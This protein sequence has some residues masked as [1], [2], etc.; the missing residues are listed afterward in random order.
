MVVFVSFKREPPL[1]PPSYGVEKRRDHRNELVKKKLQENICAGLHWAI[2]F[3]THRNL[4]LINSF[5]M[6]DSNCNASMRDCS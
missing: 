5:S 2:I 4:N 3:L 1:P 6:W